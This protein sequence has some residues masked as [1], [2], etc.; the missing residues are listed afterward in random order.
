MSRAS[1]G[2]SQSVCLHVHSCCRG[3]GR[4]GAMADS[5]HAASRTDCHAV[6]RTNDGHP[7][8]YRNA[9]WRHHL[10]FA[11]EALCVP[12][13]IGHIF[14]GRSSCPGFLE[15]L[16]KNFCLELWSESPETRSMRLILMDPG[17]AEARP[18]VICEISMTADFRSQLQ[19]MLSP[20]NG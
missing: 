14:S 2:M 8:H 19:T 10:A 6:F 17:R 1:G 12:E 15:P 13:P 11:D 9:Y 4:P 7:L 5:V 18:S 3:R 16:L 20:W